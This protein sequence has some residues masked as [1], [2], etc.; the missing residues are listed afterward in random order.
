MNTKPEG[1][2]VMK[3]V[4]RAVCVWV[5]WQM[6]V[7]GAGAWGATVSSSSV[8]AAPGAAIQAES[9]ATI[10]VHVRQS[11]HIDVPW[12]AKE[13]SVTDPAIANVSILSPRKVLVMGKAVGTTDLLLWDEKHE[14]IQ[15]PI[16]VS[17]D[18]ASLQT[19]LRHIFPGANLEASQS[20]NVLVV[21]GTLNRVEAVAELTRYLDGMNVKYLNMTRVGGAQQVLLRV[22][23]AEVDRTVI[24]ELG[25]N[26]YQANDRFFGG[27]V[28]GPD[29]G[30]ALNPLSIGVANNT[31]LNASP[32][33]PSLP[34]S[35]T[36][37]GSVSPAM[38]LFGGLENADLEMF[39]QALTENQYLRLLAE[40][41]LVALSGEEASFLA[42]G[43]IPIPV[44]QASGAG[45]GTTITIE[46]QP[47]G[48]QLKFRPTVLGDGTIRLYVGPEVSELDYSNAVTLPGSSPIPALLTRRAE[49]TVELKSGQT[50]AIAGLLNQS[51]NSRNSMVPLLGSVPV[52]GPLFRSIRYQSE[53]T[54]LVVMATATL[55]EPLSIVNTPPV[56]GVLHAPPS[57]WDFYVEGRLEGKQPPKISPSDAAYLKKLGF[58]TLKGPGSWETYDQGTAKSE[59]TQRPV[60]ARPVPVSEVATPAPAAAN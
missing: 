5:V 19:E 20:G 11:V 58:D 22:R 51:T 12:P 33:S 39:I 6:T 38:T 30:G 60:Q 2:N 49:S 50:F 24:R 35:F 7:L 36:Q 34:F 14:A 52:L 21:R 28:I 37:A 16:V 23:L 26:M 59:A 13:V 25:I 31:G 41:N 56:P 46:Y 40:P 32:G 42:G 17:V 27:D 29:K 8:A 4:R 15:M 55:V 48:I 43:E 10:Q 53:E 45:G 3:L 9:G 1:S 57:D 18:L 54:E 47:Y 44:P